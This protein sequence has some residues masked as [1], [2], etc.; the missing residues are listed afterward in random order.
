M[1]MILG[2]CNSYGGYLPSRRAYEYF[3]YEVGCSNF[4]PG[5]AE[6]HAAFLVEHLKKLKD[7]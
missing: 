1:T 5:A 2:Y 3:S 6:E 4:A 7:A